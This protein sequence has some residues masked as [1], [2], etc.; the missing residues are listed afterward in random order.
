MAFPPFQ[1]PVLSFFRG[2]DDEV[3]LRRENAADAVW[4]IELDA[5][6]VPWVVRYSVR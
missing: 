5:D 2:K 3:W 1:P 6:D 4:L